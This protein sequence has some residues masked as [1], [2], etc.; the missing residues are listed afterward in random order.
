LKFEVVKE[1]TLFS[2]RPDIVVVLYEGRLLF[3]VEIRNPK[4]A[5]G[6]D[7]DIFKTRSAAGQCLNN[8]KGMKQ[9]GMDHPFVLLSTYNSSTIVRLADDDQK[10]EEI[11]VEGSKNLKEKPEKRHLDLANS[12]E[13]EDSSVKE[14]TSPHKTEFF[15]G[16]NLTPLR[17]SNANI[18][19]CDPVDDDSVVEESSAVSSQRK[20]KMSQCFDVSNLYKVLALLVESALVSAE[21]SKE[22]LAGRHLIPR[23]GERLE[24]EFCTLSKDGFAWR[25]ASIKKTTYN[26]PPILRDGWK[27]HIVAILGQGNHGRTLLYSS[28]AGHMFACKLFLPR[29]SVA[30]LAEDREEE[31]RESLEAKQL[32]AEK[33]LDLWKTLGPENSHPYCR[34]E[35]LNGIPALT[36]PFYPPIPS[37]ERDSALPIVKETL[38]NLGSRGYVYSEIRWRN[39]GRRVKLTHRSLPMKA[40]IEITLLDLGSLEKMSPDQNLSDIIELQIRLLQ[41]RMGDPEKMPHGTIMT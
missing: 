24:G 21:R 33:E 1:A 19:E 7:S 6:D 11:L 40:K 17:A 14:Y 41:E 22:S 13:A 26:A 3:A 18:G 27:V 25:K 20:V 2:L 8:L 38:L 31:E 36:M 10:Y 9:Q 15:E 32:E 35:T 28:T 34:V 39:F 29:K 16:L 37:Q 5:Q 23:P 12:T 4:T 30:Y